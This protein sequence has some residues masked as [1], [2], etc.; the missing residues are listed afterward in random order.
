MCKGVES[1][2]YPLITV[3][4]GRRMAE[5]RGDSDRITH[6]FGLAAEAEHLIA[7]AG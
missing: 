1:H 6:F 5:A 7:A 2:E 3:K 4:L